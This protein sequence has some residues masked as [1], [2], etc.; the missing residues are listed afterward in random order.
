VTALWVN[1]CFCVFTLAIP[2]VGARTS[3]TGSFSAHRL[4]VAAERG[5]GS[6]PSMSQWVDEARQMVTAVI[7]LTPNRDLRR[8]AASALREA[9]SSLQVRLAGN[10]RRTSQSEP[11]VLHAHPSP[12][13]GHRKASTPFT[14][15]TTATASDGGSL[16]A[17]HTGS[18]ELDLLERASGGHPG[19]RLRTA[20]PLSERFTEQPA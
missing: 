14:R 7:V 9:R 8:R 20:A 12:N 3:A 11:N 5:D 19:N 16:S 17:S 2:V 4:A 1:V 15:P 18:R 10:P 6:R 13:E